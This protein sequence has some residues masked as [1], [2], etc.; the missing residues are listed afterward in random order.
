MLKIRLARRG[1][2]KQAFYDVVVAEKAR[3]VQKKYVAKLGY[4]NPLTK[5]GEGELVIDKEAVVKYINNGAEPSQTAARLLV[6][7]GIKE[8]GKFIAKR[9]SK[10]KKDKVNA[11]G[12]ED[13]LGQAPKPDPKEEEPAEEKVEVAEKEDKAKSE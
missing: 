7:N 5:G 3:A 10:P 9:V 1:R 4:Y 2:K 6:K 11:E 12:K 8:A 13:A